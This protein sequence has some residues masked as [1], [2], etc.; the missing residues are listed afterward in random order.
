MTFSSKCP[1]HPRYTR[2]CDCCRTNARRYRRARLDGLADGTWTPGYLDE[3]ATAAVRAYLLPILAAKGVS[4]ER[5]ALAAGLGRNTI[6]DVAAGR[7]QRI[8][9]VSGEA[10]LGLTVEA[11]LRHITNPN[12]L[13]DII[14]SQ[15]RLQAMACDGWGS[16]EVGPLVGVHPSMVRRHRGGNRYRRTTITWALHQAYRDLFDKI[17]SQAD[18]SGPSVQA[19]AHAE[20]LGYIPA[21]RWEDGTIDDPAA[22][23]LPPLPE[24]EDWVATTALIDDALRNP[25]PGKAADYP[26]E[27]KVEIARRAWNLLGWSYPRLA[28]LFGFKSESSVEYLLHG[29]KDRPHTRKAPQ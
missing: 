12:T 8:R 17:Q 18:P 20:R 9:T 27:I 26:R 1:K 10:I 23:P 24:T 2:G 25:A 16:Y 6:D 29:R 28:E 7:L 22:E 11:C 15:R 4:N 5:A 14:G 13:V 19:R 3:S 21:E